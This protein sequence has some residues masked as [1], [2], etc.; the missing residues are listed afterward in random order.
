M[1]AAANSTAAQYPRSPRRPHT[2]ARCGDSSV[3]HA[4]LQCDASRHGLH[5]CRTRCPIDPIGRA[6]VA[7]HMVHDRTSGATQPFPPRSTL[8]QECCRR[9]VRRVP[10]H[11]GRRSDST[12]SLATRGSHRRDR[13]GARFRGVSDDPQ[14]RHQRPAAVRPVSRLGPGAGACDHQVLLV[15]VRDRVRHRPGRGLRPQDRRARLAATAQPAALARRR[16]AVLV[17]GADRGGDVRPPRPRRHRRHAAVPEF[18]VVR[19]DSRLLRDRVAVDS[20][21]VAAVGEDA[22]LVALAQSDTGGVR[23]VVAAAQLRFLGRAAAAGP[24]GR[25]PGLLHLGAAGAW[26]VDS[27]RSAS[28]RS[29]AALVRRSAYAPGA[30]R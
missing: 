17:Q 21:A 4:L 28:R 25:T 22:G 29:V 3:T 20:V 2:P 15:V 7:Y 13:S 11:P 27:R 8:L 12:R 1:G 5:A 18:P 9:D 6:D 10:R 19:R 24:A 16:G 14:S 26:A 30:C 23:L